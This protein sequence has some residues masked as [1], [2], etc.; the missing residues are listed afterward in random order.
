MVPNDF[1]IAVLCLLLAITIAACGKTQPYIYKRG[2]FNREA[3][4]FNQPPKDRS[5]VTI[6][7]NKLSTTPEAVFEMADAECRNYAKRAR[8]SHQDFGNC[9]LATPVEAHFACEKP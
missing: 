4:D 5:S 7:Y 1:R 3:E 8:P 6:C 2:E 9:P